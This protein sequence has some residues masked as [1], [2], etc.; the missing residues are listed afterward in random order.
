VEAGTPQSRCGT[1][2]PAAIDRWA[3]IMPS[4]RISESHR[5]DSPTNLRRFSQRSRRSWLT[6]AAE[7]RNTAK[8]A[9]ILDAY[10]T[11]PTLWTTFEPSSQKER[12]PGSENR[13]EPQALRPQARGLK[14]SAEGTAERNLRVS[15][16]R[17]GA[18]NL[19]GHRV[20]KF[21]DTG[22]LTWTQRVTFVFPIAQLQV[23]S[24]PMRCLTLAGG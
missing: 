4:P 9:S 23:L 20:Y 11:S 14:R 16:P 6:R 13:R 21:T 5:A 12:V 17:L 3:E 8:L 18:T 10:F 2:H 7:T 15:L 1:R 24:E 22:I 19:V